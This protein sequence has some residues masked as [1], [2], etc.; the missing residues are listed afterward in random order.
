MIHISCRIGLQS[1]LLLTN[2]YFPF[3]ALGREVANVLGHSPNE[4]P[5]SAF[6][7]TTMQLQAT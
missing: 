1:E 6:Q 5:P 7:V 4:P 2:G 3:C